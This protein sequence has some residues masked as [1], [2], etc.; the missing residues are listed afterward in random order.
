MARDI[1][2]MI[3]GT[4]QQLQVDET[5]VLRLARITTPVA[6]PVTFYDPGVGTQGAPSLN[7]FDGSDLAKLAGLA[8]GGGLFDKVEAAYRFLM[9]EYAPGDRI[10]MFGFSRGAYVVRALA[11]MLAKIGLLERGRENLVPYVARV[12]ATGDNWALAGR[13]RKTFSDRQPDIHFLGLWDTVKSVFRL[14]FGHV[15]GVSLPW[16]F[17]NPRVRTVRHALALDERR[18]FFRTN[19]WQEGA[20]RPGRTDVRQVWFAGCHSDVGG[21]F[22]NAKSGLSKLAL[23]WLLDEA[24]AAGLGVDQALAARVLA[25]PPPDPLAPLHDSLT[26]F[27]W[28]GEIIPERPYRG[29]TGER[30]GWRL[31]LGSP[32]F[33]PEHSLIH[34]SVLD[35]RAGDPAYRPPNLPRDYRVEPWPSAPRSG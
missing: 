12:Y 3:D 26:G 30:G 4:G 24:I 28:L 2:V 13:M 21:G 33:V 22:P 23:Q 25:K 8:L 14:E 9:R 5:N 34:Q 17:Q 15:A 27:W 16:T 6:G 31:P 18:A 35:R 10:F 1:V 29:P 7:P 32:R 19:L 11:G 20:T